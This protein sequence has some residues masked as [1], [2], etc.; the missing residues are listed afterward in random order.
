MNER[1][2]QLIVEPGTEIFTEGDFGDCAYIVERGSVEVSIGR[3]ADRMVLSRRQAGEVFGEVA[4]ID[5]GPRT[6]TVTALEPCELLMINAEQLH[7]RLDDCDP[8]L[9]MCL[10]VL[11]DRFRD[12]IRSRL[13]ESSRISTDLVVGLSK[14]QHQTSYE[15]VVGAL[16]LEHE[17]AEAIREE[18]FEL[19]YQPM[20]DLANGCIAG[21]EALV[22][23]RHR[24]RGLIPPMLFIPAAETSGLIAPLGRWCLR[25]A[26]H[27]QRRF[28]GALPDGHPS[29]DSLFISVNVTSRDLADDQFVPFIDSLL[30]DS[31]IA[32]HNLKLE[33]TETLLMQ[34]PEIACETLNRCRVKGLSIAIDDFGTGYSSLSY[35]HR[36]PIDTLKIDRSFVAAMAGDETNRE[37]IRTIIG[38]GRQLNKPVVAEGIEDRGQAAAIREMGA[39]YG[40]G[41]YFSKPCDESN[42]ASLLR[43]WD[44]D[45]LHR[46]DLMVRTG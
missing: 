29:K 38:L 27:A 32:P 28:V 13:V 14:E 23:W 10:H 12:M 46:P 16:R 30:E 31:G 45:F 22:R 20:I 43:H 35:L 44:T 18:D 4:I 11:I 3:G 1:L 24:E 34:D 40:Q 21:F 42:A 33:I 9:R 41:Y 39:T 17:L 25:E 2:N 8:I 26:C 15:Q 5:S 36:F 19:H 6:A 37:I 7:R